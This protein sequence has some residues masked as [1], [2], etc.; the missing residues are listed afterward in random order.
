MVSDQEV[1]LIRPV[2][3]ALTLVIVLDLGLHFLK[4]LPLMIIN[5]F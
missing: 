3:L 4:L 1:V 5:L 2:E